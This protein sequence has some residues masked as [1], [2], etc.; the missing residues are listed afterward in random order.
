MS[1]WDTTQHADHPNPQPSGNR[2][3][4]RK[5]PRI[6]YDRIILVALVLIGLICLLVL[7]VKQCGKKDTTENHS[8]GAAATTTQISTEPLERTL[9]LTAEDV[10]KGSLILV[11]AD[12]VYTFAA[13]DVSL[14]T[15]YEGRNSCYGVSDMEVSLD[16]DVIDHFNQLMQAYYNIYDN[17][18]IMIVS[19]Y[20]TREEQAAYYESKKTML[21]GGYSDY[22]TA[23]SFDLVIYPNGTTSNY[24]AATGDYAWIAEH[25]AE[26][27][28]VLR[29]PDGK[30][31]KTGISPRAYTFRYVGVPHALYMYENGLC[32]EEYLEEIQGYSADKPLTIDTDGG[33]WKVFYMQANTSGST[34]IAVPQD[35]TYTVSGDNVGG[36]IVA[37]QEAGTAA[38]T[39]AVDATGDAAETTVV[40]ETTAE[41]AE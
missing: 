16:A 27:G 2:P 19:G 21:P 15:V 40:T 26:Y 29:Y 17:S 35:A 31:D 30:A 13:D 28:F 14:E 36:F 37:Y 33:E 1:A 10:H 24:Y 3:P 38:V 9:A 32:L 25:A 23:R 6:R 12:H 20:R 22:H 5:K 34:Q 18:D 11:N 7:G 39:T 8:S 41:N 4:R